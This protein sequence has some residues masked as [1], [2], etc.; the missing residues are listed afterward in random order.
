MRIT[1][2]NKNCFEILRV[3]S[4]LEDVLKFYVCFSPFFAPLNVI[5]FFTSAL[6]F[7][8]SALG[9]PQVIPDR[10]YFGQPGLIPDMKLKLKVLCFCITYVI[11]DYCFGHLIIAWSFLGR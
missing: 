2:R 4:W 8:T 3:F 6:G 1:P 9:L 10:E 7:F 11:V 5:K